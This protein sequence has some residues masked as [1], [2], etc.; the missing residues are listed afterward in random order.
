VELRHGDVAQRT[1]TSNATGDFSFETVPAGE[2]RIRFS[3]SGFVTTESVLTV[4]VR[5][6]A[7]RAGAW[8]GVLSVVAAIDA[9]GR[10][11]LAAFRS[12]GGAG[13]RLPGP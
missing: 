12:A 10:V 5:S 3:L 13:A 2:Y 8:P 7:D 9:C 1:T 6:A 4:G 11:A